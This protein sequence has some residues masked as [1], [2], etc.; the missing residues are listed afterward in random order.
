M[1]DE[2]YEM[3]EITETAEAAEVYEAPDLGT[4]E[5]FAEDTERPLV[6]DMSG[7]ELDELT[8]GMSAEQLRTLRDKLE[9]R[10]PEML[11]ALGFHE[12]GDDD[13]EPWQKVLVLKRR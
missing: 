2:N 7:E 5:T 3:S 9:Q 8:E 6:T 13:D 12:E 1:C 4:E 11:D 10:D